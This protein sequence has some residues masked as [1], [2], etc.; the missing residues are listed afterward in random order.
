MNKKTFLIVLAA[1]MLAGCGSSRTVHVNDDASI[2]SSRVNQTMRG[3][4][5]RVQYE[6]GRSEYASNVTVARDST[7]WLD[8]GSMQVRTVATSDVQ[9]I[10]VVRA[11]QGALVG[12][13]AGIVV[14]VATGLLRAQSEGDDPI[15]EFPNRTKSEKMLIWPAA[16]S[17]YALL[18]TV[19]I[20]AIVG[21]KC[22]FRLVHD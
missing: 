18:A 14:G 6:N 13:G 15:G 3:R 2:G 9:K 20:G 16:H 5:A 7:T 10:T 12:V 17:T 1:L 8:P 4:L 21:R 11:G 19:P 22:T